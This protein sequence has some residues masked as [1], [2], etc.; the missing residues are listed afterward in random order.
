MKPLY[1]NEQFII[2]KSF[3]KLPC[4]CYTCSGTFY[5]AKTHIKDS[6][7][8]NCKRTGKYCSKKCSSESKNLKITYNCH[9]CEKECN[10]K[11]SQ[12]NLSKSGF[13][14]CSRSCTTLYHNR[15]KKYGTNR[16]K[17][18][19][20][21]E[22]QLIALYPGLHIDFNKKDAINSELDIYIPSLK[23]A[24]ELNGI[25]HFEPIFGSK[26][27]NQTQDNDTYKYKACIDN[28]IDLCI[29][30][31]SSQKYFKEY[32]SKKYLEIIIN[33]IKERQN[34]H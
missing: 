13:N 9:N 19:Q 16:S 14:F 26:K 33:I 22:E 24:F 25:F 15:N 23:L 20:Y 30:N 7:N 21:I 28:E 31:T 4:K 1:T 10:K 3:D 11:K 29:I 27:L 8:P 2:A 32:T 18:E 6:L 17:L 5:L 12:F 34:I